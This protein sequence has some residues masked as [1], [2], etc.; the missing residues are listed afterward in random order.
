MGCGGW[1]A[2]RPGFHQ[3]IL[4][5]AGGKVETEMVT[6]V[7]RAC[8]G[9]IWRTSTP[10]RCAPCPGGVLDTQAWEDRRGISAAVMGDLP[11]VWA[12][13]G[14]RW[15]PLWLIQCIRRRTDQ[16]PYQT[17]GSVIELSLAAERLLL[18]RLNDRA[19]KTTVRRRPHGRPVALAPAQGEGFASRRQCTSTQP[20]LT[21]SAPYLPALVACAV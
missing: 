7:R 4:L 9:S 11:V 15:L 2:H 17:R 16:N 19:A 21:D 6:S 1:Q 14:S 3:S 12:R 5:C 18:H 8:I 20:V 10:H 13:Q